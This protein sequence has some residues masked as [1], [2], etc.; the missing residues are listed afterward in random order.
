MCGVLATEVTSTAGVWSVH[1]R[2]LLLVCGVSAT[3]I[4]ATGVW[5]AGHRD[6]CYWCVECWPQRH[7]LLAALVCGVSA[8]EMMSMAGHC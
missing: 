2:Y 1:Q 7:L 4:P 8:T 3:E 5:S 6:I